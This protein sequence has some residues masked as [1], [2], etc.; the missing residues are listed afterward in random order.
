MLETHLRIS[1]QAGGGGSGQS[2][3][4]SP[5]GCPATCRRRGLSLRSRGEK[6]AAGGRRGLCSPLLPEPPMCPRGRVSR[7]D[8]LWS[9]GQRGLC[10]HGCCIEGPGCRCSG[11]ALWLTG[12]HRPGGRSCLG[13]ARA[14]RRSDGPGLA[15]T[16]DGQVPA[17]GVSSPTSS[18]PS[19]GLEA[20]IAG[21]QSRAMSQGLQGPRA[22]QSNAT[23]MAGTQSRAER[24][25][26]D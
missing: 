5:G 13:P 24:C 26:Q 4:F 11:P 8:A 1:R 17:R 10:H 3:P 2:P 25:H 12:L 16:G 9:R 21:T 23:R 18:P 20:K 7:L 14:P 19:T 22:E 15:T 6:G